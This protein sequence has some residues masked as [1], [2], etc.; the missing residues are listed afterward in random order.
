MELSKEKFERFLKNEC[1]DAETQ[2]VLA[3]LKEH[4]DV[5]EHYIPLDDWVADDKTPLDVEVTERIL[6][7]IRESYVPVKRAKVTRLL[8]RY[9]A[10]ASLIGIVVLA[11]AKFFSGKTGPAA[12]PTVVAIQHTG[13]AKELKMVENKTSQVM[14]VKLSDS[15][16]ATLYPNSSLQYLPVFEKG[17]RDLYLRG[18]AQFK[19]AKDASRPFTV[20]TADIATTVLGTRFLVTEQPDRKVSVKLMEGMVRVWSKH[21]GDSNRSVILNPGDEVAVLGGQ[22]SDYSLVHNRIESRGNPVAGTKGIIDNEPAEPTNDLVFKNQ[23][24]KDVFRKIEERFDVTI[25]DEKAPGIQ[26]KLFTG[27]FLER[28]S[29]D[30]IA[31]TICSFYNLQYRVEGSTVTISA[32]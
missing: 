15:S 10:A 19:V 25:N 13:G 5:L 4:P 6:Q 8:V 24:L 14:R 21:T 27:R 18:K 17:K 3:Y 26:E 20:Y 22:F 16:L 12:G 29:L 23:K 2:E 11:G 28:D 7:Q 32:K 9:T 31:K 1:T 30:F